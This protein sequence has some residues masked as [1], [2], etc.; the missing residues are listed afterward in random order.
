MDEI[1][2]D[3]QTTDSPT[4]DSTFTEEYERR[5]F[6]G[7]EFGEGFECFV[8]KPDDETEQKE[9]ARWTINQLADLPEQF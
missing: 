5:R 4:Q 2:I 6:E 8:F 7:E 3:V 1:E 9:L